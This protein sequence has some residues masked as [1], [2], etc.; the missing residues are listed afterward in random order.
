M[1]RESRMISGRVPTIVITLVMRSPSQQSPT[2]SQNVSGWSGSNRACVQ[3]RVVSSVSPV[4]VM[5]CTHIVGMSTTAGRVARDVEG[6]D[7][8]VKTRRKVIRRLCR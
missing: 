2:G 1:T 5:L 4:L 3:N 8:V 6:D 7:L